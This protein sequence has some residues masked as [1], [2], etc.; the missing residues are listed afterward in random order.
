[1]ELNHSA[2]DAPGTSGASR[3]PSRLQVYV[4][5]VVAVGTVIMTVAVVGRPPWQDMAQAVQS[6][7]WVDSGALPLLMLG[8]ALVLGEL[9]PIRIS[10]T[11]DE[12]DSI[13]IST[14]FAVALVLLGPLSFV[15]LVHSVAVIFDDV[16]RRRSLHKIAFNVAQYAITLAAAREAYCLLVPLADPTETDV[17]FLGGYDALTP[18]TW[19][20]FTALLAGAVF[21][22]VN[23]LLTST[24]IAFATGSS[25]RVMV[26]DDFR[27]QVATSGV[28]VSLGPVAALAASV[29]PLM[30]PL[31]AAPVLAVHRSADLALQRQKQAYHDTLTGLANREL[32]RARAEAALT[33]VGRTGRN[34]S[35]M[36]I[37]LDHFKEINDTLGHQVGDDLIREVAIRLDEA[38]P[39]GSTVARLGG[40]EFAVLLADVPD[41]TVAEGVAAYLLQVMSAPFAVGGVRVVVQGSIGI[42][43]APTHGDDVHTLMKHADIALYEAKR[44]RARY[45][46]YSPEKDTHTPQRLALV[47]DLLQGIDEGQLFCEFQPQVDIR[48]GQV[49]GAEALVRWRH[50]TRGL[51]GP[52]DFIEPAESAGLIAPITW[53]VID[54]ALRV[55]RRWRERGVDLAVSVNLSVRHLTD[56]A[57][58]DRICAALAEWDAPPSSLTVEVTESGVMNDPR[59]AAMVLQQLRR[60]GVGV[61]I[62]DYGTGNTSLTY[63]KQLDIT[64]LKIDKSFI[65]HLR[66][67]DEDAI[68]VRSTVELGRDLGLRIVAEGVE[69]E[70]TLEWLRGTGCDLV[71][72]FYLGRPMAADDLEVVARLTSPPG[73]PA[74]PTTPAPLRLVESR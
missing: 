25:V 65:T 31:L 17:T 39:V 64:E 73:R 2:R 42:A 23:Q 63:L 36:M 24:V 18:G 27:F 55:Q 70:E 12:A 52:D 60:L 71:Q 1:V 53:F 62:D 40:D 45:S 26:V 15:I 13:T 43:I 38:R 57:L 11:A 48:S 34:A 28:L 10:R 20:L 35:V 22:L 69:D 16:R 46:S 21:F 67:S 74:T 66:A 59:R 29:Q 6:T 72:G 14:T 30:V 5:S 33:E 7:G 50:P 44:E 9:R 49:V 41:A 19:V 58:P 4:W 37:D 32:F 54:E 51:I 61:A 3:L 8:V 47:A 68:I 56:M